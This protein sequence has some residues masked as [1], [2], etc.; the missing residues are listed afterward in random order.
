MGHYLNGPEDMANPWVAPLK[1][2]DFS[3]L[4]PTYLLTAGFDPRHDDNELFID[5]L[6]QAGVEAEFHSEYDPRLHVHAR[7]DRPGR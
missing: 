3:V 4:P 6:A 1:M 2:P 5:A 7:R